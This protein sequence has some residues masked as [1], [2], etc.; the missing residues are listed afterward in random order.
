MKVCGFTIIRNTIKYDFPVIEAIE[1]ILPICDKFIVLVGNSDDATLELMQ[2][3][4]SD[5]IEIHQSIWDDNLRT[6]GQVLAVETNKA[7]DLIA[8]EYTWAFYI[9]ADEVVHE[10]YLTT[11]QH[12]MQKHA[13]NDKVEGL[14]FN[15]VHFYGNYDYI[16]DERGW[17]RR[18]IRIIKNDKTIRSWLDA[19]GFRKNNQKL[20]VV[21]IDAEI[22][23][24][25]WVKDPIT[26]LRKTTDVSK[27]WNDDKTL[28]KKA[29]NAQVFDFTNKYS[30]ALFKGTH[31]KVM[32]ARIA[33]KN[34]KIELDINKRN[35]KFKNKVLFYYEKLTNHRPFEYKN[36]KIIKG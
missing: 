23:H 2:S 3:I 19:Q 10:K 35:L 6:G 26:M 28:E 31:P 33:R 5:K 15:Y 21:H 32:Q 29:S 22:F 12:E 18:E 1:S 25:G 36:Y 9:Q 34:W 13:Q 11:I 8:P 20:K 24:Y 7:F 27:F 17:Y 4:K 30:V 16:G 14:L